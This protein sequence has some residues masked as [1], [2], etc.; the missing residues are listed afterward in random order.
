MKKREQL[1]RKDNVIIF[2]DLERRLT[3]KGLESLQK[4]SFTEAVRY[5]EEARDLDPENA[6]T[7][8][9][10]VLAYFETGSMKEARDLAKE[11]LHKG[12]GDYF[13]MIDLYVMIIIQLHEYEE[14]I[15]TIEALIEEKELPSEKDEHF[16]TILQFSKKMV[17]NKPHDTKIELQEM[18]EEESKREELNLFAFQDP[19]EQMLLV[20]KLANQ[21]IRPYIH[22]IRAYLISEEG[23]PFLK[24]ILLNVLKEQEYDREVE[25]IKLNKSRIVI[26]ADLPDVQSQEKQIKITNILRDILESDDPVLFENI[27]SFVE[28][29]F[30]LTFPYE[31]EPVDSMAW[32]AAYHF[33]ALEYHGM[34]VDHIKLT[35][36][37]QTS[38]ED[39]EKA[40]KKIREVEEISY[41]II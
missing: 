31:I 12:I 3:E 26:P 20:A 24:T 2:P 14:I 19:K 30:F 40:L 15:S 4:K 5:F 35:D 39:F 6:D 28:R 36:Q 13:Q 38:N 17:E 33:I 32:A 18:I 21:N 27:K 1:R 10:L 16:L 23:H 11:M 22:E 29:Q 37:Y 41:P 25:V 9:G 34:C 8:I 7:L